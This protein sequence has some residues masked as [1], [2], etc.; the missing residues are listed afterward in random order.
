[1]VHKS[2]GRD[3]GRS[4][5]NLRMVRW[6]WMFYRANR[7]ASC[8][9]IGLKMGCTDGLW[10]LGWNAFDTRHFRYAHLV[11]TC[12]RNWL[13]AVVLIDN[14]GMGQQCVSNIRS[15]TYCGIPSAGRLLK[16]LISKAGKGTPW[17]CS[18]TSKWLY[19]YTIIVSGIIHIHKYIY[20]NN[21]Y[22]YIYICMYM[23]M[24]LRIHIHTYIIMHTYSYSTPAG[25][26]IPHRVYP[27]RT[28]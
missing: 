28:R 9:E 18:S 17:A 23:Y 2:R 20:I 24:Y 8:D 19:R 6:F 25:D 4:V 12:W 3:P 21:I 27:G 5:A 26:K 16:E 1:M 14:S 22:I 10:I 11:N 13:G 15:S 7:C